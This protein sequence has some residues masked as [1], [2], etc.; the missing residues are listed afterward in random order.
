MLNA[1]YIN[2]AG[3][4]CRD[5]SRR[6]ILHYVA[7][8]ASGERQSS[9]AIVR[10]AQDLVLERGL[11]GFTMDDLARPGYPAECCS[12]RPKAVR[13]HPVVG[14]PDGRQIDRA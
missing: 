11:N 10:A 3:H 4:G 5:P 12:T 13:G 6:R 8:S 7:D 1:H 9:E 14:G 2:S